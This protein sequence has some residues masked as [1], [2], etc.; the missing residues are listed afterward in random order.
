MVDPDL[1]VNMQKPYGSRERGN[2]KPTYSIGEVGGG[3]ENA[4]PG[5][6]GGG[7][8]LSG[9]N[10]KHITSVEGYKNEVVTMLEADMILNERSHWMHLAYNLN[11]AIY[12][13]FTEVGL[14]HTGGSF[15]VSSSFP[16][17]N[18]IDMVTHK[19]NDT[20]GGRGSKPTWRLNLECHKINMLRVVYLVSSAYGFFGCGLGKAN[21]QGRAKLIPENYAMRGKRT[22]NCDK[23][24]CIF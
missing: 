17:T 19:I 16:R 7:V 10:G 23:L 3:G 21:C 18:C 20:C 2:A 4:T 6:I 8:D 15:I 9:R 14:G 5:A 11:M 1:D 13:S 22:L 24:S 12:T